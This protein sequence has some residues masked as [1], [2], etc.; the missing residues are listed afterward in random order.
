MGPWFIRDPGAP[1]RPGF[2]TRT[3]RTLVARGRIRPDTVLRGPTTRQFW[4]PARR[5]PGVSALLGMCHNCQG[6]TPEPASRC[7]GC[8][9]DVS[10][11]EDRQGLG[12]GPIVPVPG[13]TGGGWDS[14][15]VP[16]STPGQ[17]GMPQGAAADIESASTI[18]R[19]RR[20]NRA[21]RAWLLLS[22]GAAAVLGGVAIG[23]AL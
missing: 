7:P 4:M 15:A 1:F 20:S 8:D 14:Q 5:T 11:P 17:A 13:Q 3:L 19:L 6:A 10:L 16:E 2:S 21:L 23:L 9:A 12:L 22:L 18:A